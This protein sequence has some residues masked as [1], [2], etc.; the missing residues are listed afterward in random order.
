[1][2]VVGVLLLAM[3]VAVIWLLWDVA[4]NRWFG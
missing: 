1:M 4:V 2:N 3:I